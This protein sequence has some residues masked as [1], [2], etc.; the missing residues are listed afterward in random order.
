MQTSGR[1]Y[2]VADCS[3]ATL[4]TYPIKRL[5]REV[6]PLATDADIGS[7]MPASRTRSRGLS[8]FSL[9][10]TSSCPVN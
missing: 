7:C 4:T 10:F 5:A 8:Y 2:L 6:T 9:P 3:Q 1:P